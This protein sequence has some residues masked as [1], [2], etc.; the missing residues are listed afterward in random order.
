MI[1]RTLKSTMIIGYDHIGFLMIA[2]LLFI[3]GSLPLVTISVTVLSLSSM[4]GSLIRGRNPDFRAEAA[5]AGPYWGKGGLLALVCLLVSSVLAADCFILVRMR[6][7]HPWIAWLTL[8]F[9]LCLLTLWLLMQIYLVPMF[10]WRGFAI[11]G[12]LKGSL[13]LVIDNFGAS[14]AFGA[15][16]LAITAVMLF[17]GAGP[18]FLMFSFQCLLQNQIFKNVME[19]YHGPKSAS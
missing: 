11:R 10:L 6:E 17:S 8:G 2:N 14:L 18:V 3:A 16:F 19:K 13:L 5:R 15:I 12:A 9:V 4:T 1:L 7:A